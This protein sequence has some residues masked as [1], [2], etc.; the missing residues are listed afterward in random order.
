M[1]MITIIIMIMLIITMVNITQEKKKKTASIISH[2][3]LFTYGYTN[4]ITRNSHQSLKWPQLDF[5]HRFSY[6]LLLRLYEGITSDF[7]SQLG[8]LVGKTTIFSPV[9]H[10]FFL[11]FFFHE[12]MLRYK[13]LGPR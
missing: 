9:T 5:D 3:S 8:I 13:L 11:F 7:I 2:I 1:I 12:S 4:V 6:S 10:N